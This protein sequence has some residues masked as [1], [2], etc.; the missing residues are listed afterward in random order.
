[1]FYIEIL[2]SSYRKGKLPFPSDS[3]V[4]SSAVA[5]CCLEPGGLLLLAGT[6]RSHLSPPW[7]QLAASFYQTLFISFPSLATRAEV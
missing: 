3:G 1:M 2:E 5:E 7:L 4:A 6:A